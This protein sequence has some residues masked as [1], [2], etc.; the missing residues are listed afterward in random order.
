MEEINQ[1]NLIE[2]LSKLK[3]LKNVC[4]H[5]KFKGWN[6]WNPNFEPELVKIG[7]IEQEVSMEPP[8]SYWG[9]KAPISLDEYPYWH[10]EIHQCPKCNELFF[11][12]NEDG[13]HSRQ[14]R[15]RLI[16]KELI[17]IES[18]KPTQNCQIISSPYKYA[19]YKKT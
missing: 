17:D 6:D 14:K 9:E 3:T 2:F 1:N 4:D 15:Y 19:I 16:Q 7:Q 12:Y 18:I 13:G 5:S 8:K 11:F 10:C